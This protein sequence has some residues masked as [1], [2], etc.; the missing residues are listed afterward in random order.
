MVDGHLQDELKK[1]GIRDKKTLY[2]RSIIL[3][4]PTMTSPSSGIFNLF[5]IESC[6]FHAFDMCY[7]DPMVTGNTCEE[8]RIIQSHK[9]QFQCGFPHVLQPLWQLAS[10]AISAYQ[11]VD[12]DQVKNREEQSFYI[13]YSE[14]AKSKSAKV[15]TR[16]FEYLL[17]RLTST[18]LIPS[19][20]LQSPLLFQSWHRLHDY[21]SRFGILC[22]V[23]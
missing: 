14:T 22:I 8:E 12:I 1:E 15:S 20:P 5:T 11:H 9:W 23:S 3:C 2:N 16:R 4:D 19:Y 18:S 13:Q 10:L 6:N 7:N 17:D 21:S